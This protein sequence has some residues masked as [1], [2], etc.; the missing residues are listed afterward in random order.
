[1]SIY[2]RSSKLPPSR[3][4]SSDQS[5]GSLYVRTYIESN[6][7]LQR[8]LLRDCVESGWLMFVRLYARAP[9]QG[10]VNF[11]LRGS[12]GAHPGYLILI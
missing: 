3:T 1:M 6:R 11:G 7:L 8:A 2:V 4:L 5:T 10:R 12:R 9:F